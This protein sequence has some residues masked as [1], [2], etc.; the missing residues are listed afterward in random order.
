MK[1]L[2]VDL[3]DDLH[4]QMKMQALREDKSVKQYITD[5]IKKNLQK[6]KE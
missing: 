3:E 1:R 2:I 5:I 6:E 4:K